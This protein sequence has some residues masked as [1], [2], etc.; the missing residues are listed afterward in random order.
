LLSVLKL[1][2]AVLLT[3]DPALV[4]RELN[5]SEAAAYYALLDRNRAHLTQFGN[6]QAEGKA[7]LAW[8]KRSLKRPAAGLR[9]G[10]W[11][12]GELVG[13]IELAAWAQHRFTLAYWLGSEHVGRGLM[14]HALTRL[15]QHGRESFG[16]T[17]FF[18]GVTHGNSRSAAVL[19][20]LGYEIAIDHCDHTVFSRVA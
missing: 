16:A 8:V 18:A 7:T 19:R 2:H 11:Y 10:L 20:G 17:A 4:L 15:M 5:V 14:T 6:Y 13:R 12:S 9:F 3:A 1:A